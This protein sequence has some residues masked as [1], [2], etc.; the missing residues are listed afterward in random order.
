MTQTFHIYYNKKQPQFFK[1]NNHFFVDRRG[2]S[3][4]AFTWASTKQRGALGT[5][6]HKIYIPAN[7]LPGRKK[8]EKGN[9]FS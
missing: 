9:N 1:S 5:Q 2:S 8:G 6:T 3:L 4:G 7:K